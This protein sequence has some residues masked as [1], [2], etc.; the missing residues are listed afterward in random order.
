MFVNEVREITYKTFSWFNFEFLYLF[1]LVFLF[2]TFFYYSRWIILSTITYNK[3]N[4]YKYCPICGSQKI[5]KR[6][7]IGGGNR[8]EKCLDCKNVIKDESHRI[9]RGVG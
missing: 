1:V 4:G 6:G 5:D 3:I 2:T 7:F 9:E 8:Y